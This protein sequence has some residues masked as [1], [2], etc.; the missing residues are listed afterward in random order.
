MSYPI[1]PMTSP[2]PLERIP[3]D[4]DPP[5]PW[6]DC[7]HPSLTVTKIRVLY[8]TRV[9]RQRGKFQLM[10]GAEVGHLLACSQF[11]QMWFDEIID[12]IR[13]V[14]GSVPEAFAL[15]PLLESGTFDI[16]AV[17]EQDNYIPI[18]DFSLDLELLSVDDFHN[19]FDFLAECAEVR[20]YEFLVLQESY[21]LTSIVEL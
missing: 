10:P 12:A 18:V 13:E 3:L 14:R 4:C 11:D 6:P 8:E 1:V 17:I 7:V 20:R 2:H 19:P 16:R 5:L 9:K 15:N 21:V